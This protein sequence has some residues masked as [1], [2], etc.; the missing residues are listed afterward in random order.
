MRKPS[1]KVLAVIIFLYLVLAA[2][3]YTLIIK[4]LNPLIDPIIGFLFLLLYPVCVLGILL[5]LISS[6]TGWRPTLYGL[7]KKPDVKDSS[8]E[9]SLEKS[10]ILE[11]QSVDSIICYNCKDTF[12]EK[13]NVCNKCGA[14]K[15]RC[16]V[17]GLDL[18]PE[19]DPEDTIVI[20]PCCSVYVHIEH[21]L[22]WLKVQEIC[23]NCKLEI[24]EE[25]FFKGYII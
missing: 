7:K 11:E 9:D 2:Y 12:I 4:Y 23:P 3:F 10:L 14:P 5:Y 17:C 13:E 21:M 18:S 8:S 19:T 22:E 6:M 24:I 15:P 16:I 25:D 1:K 20:T